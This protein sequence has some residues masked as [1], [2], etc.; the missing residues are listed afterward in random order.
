MQTNQNFLESFYELEGV[1]GV[2]CLLSKYEKYIFSIC[3]KYSN[4]YIDAEDNLQEVMIKV[5]QKLNAFT[6]SSKFSTWLYSITR[7]YCIDQLKAKQKESLKLKDY[8][9]TSNIEIEEEVE[10]LR[11]LYIGTI[12]QLGVEDQ[13]LLRMKYMESKSIVEIA[14]FYNVSQSCIKMRL[15]RVKE[16]VRQLFNVAC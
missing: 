11:H 5:M 14:Q 16:K 6:A 13:I 4:S 8:F 2:G 3:L 9:L 7:N 1:Q 15:S 12:A 10:D